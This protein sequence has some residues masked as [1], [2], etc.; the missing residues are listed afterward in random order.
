MTSKERAP[1][2]NGGSQVDHPDDEASLALTTNG[3]NLDVQISFV[4]ADIGALAKRYIASS[5]DEEA[6]IIEVIF[7]LEACRQRFRD[8]LRAVTVR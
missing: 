1:A 5:E 7:S 6:A 8:S 3:E 4:L 2:R